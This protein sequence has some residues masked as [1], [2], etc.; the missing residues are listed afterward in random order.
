MEGTKE[1]E[2]VWYA[3]RRTCNWG[4]GKIETNLYQELIE[5]Y[6]HRLNEVIAENEYCCYL[7]N[8]LGWG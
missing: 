3:S 5:N 2:T 7:L 1:K 8:I 6:F 4:M